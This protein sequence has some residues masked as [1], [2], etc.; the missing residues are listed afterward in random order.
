VNEGPGRELGSQDTAGGYDDDDEADEYEDA[1]G[2]GGSGSLG[3]DGLFVVKDLCHV[4]K[5]RPPPPSS[6][7]RRGRKGQ[8]LEV[9]EL[10]PFRFE[11]EE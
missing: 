2:V 7:A 11:T 8:R 6:A 10:A 3:D 1:E 5:V 4:D 9:E